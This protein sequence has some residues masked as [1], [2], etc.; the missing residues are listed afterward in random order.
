[1]PELPEVEI[2]RRDLAR[3]TI[4]KKIA[5]FGVLNLKTLRGDKKLFQQK[6][7]N[8]YFKYIRRHGK[9]LIFKLASG[10]YLLVNLY[11]KG[12]LV[13]RKYKENEKQDLPD[14]YTKILFE[15]ED[16]SRMFFNNKGQFGYLQILSDN[17]LK[18]MRVKFGIDPTDDKFSLN[19]FYKILRNKT[20]SIKNILMN[21]DLL[22]GI[23]AIYADEICLEA[24][25]MPD[26]GIKLLKQS[27]IKRL[28]TAICKI[29]KKSIIHNGISGNYIK[30]ISVH[31]R[32][33]EKCLECNLGVVKKILVSNR[34]TF[35]CP[36]CQN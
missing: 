15:F 9:I 6:I 3:K 33:G 1:M 35:Y 18:R 28:Y 19:S 24:R 25:V 34:K 31:N 26:K 2:L 21:K 10:Y 27:E 23:G 12:D 17:E 7:K 4:N 20:T 16:K 11:S 13:Y 29:L 36:V 22:V 14:K 8:S 5:S 32:E 30:F